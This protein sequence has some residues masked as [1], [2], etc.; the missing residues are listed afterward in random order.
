MVLDAYINITDGGGLTNGTYTLFTY[1]GTLTY[2][3]TLVQMA[4]N[5]NLAYVV[6][7]STNGQVNLVVSPACLT[8][9]TIL[10]PQSNTVSDVTNI[11]VQVCLP[12]NQEL[13]GI[14]FLLDGEPSMSI[15]EPGWSNDLVSAEWDTVCVTNG[16]HTLQ[17]FVSYSDGF[18]D[19]SEFASPIIWVQTQNDIILPGFPTVFGTS[20]P[21]TA[22]LP[23]SNATWTVN[24]LDPSNNTLRTYSDSTTTGRIDIVWDGNDSNGV[25][26][27]GDYVLVQ[28]STLPAGGGNP[29]VMRPAPK[30]TVGG[31]PNGFLLSYEGDLI[32]G[33][34]GTLP[35]SFNE[36]MWEITDIAGSDPYYTTGPTTYNEIGEGDAGVQTPAVWQS[37]L[38]WLSDPGTANLYYFGHGDAEA[39]GGSSGASAS[40]QAIG[41]ALGNGYTRLWWWPFKKLYHVKHTYRFVYLDGCDT[42]SGDLCVAF[43]IERIRTNDTYYAANGIQ[44][45]AFLGWTNIMQYALVTHADFNADLA[46]FDDGVFY[47]WSQGQTPLIG[48]VNQAR[49]PY[50]S[51]LPVPAIWGDQQLRWNPQ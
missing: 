32:Y 23:S 29:Q 4:P 34:G 38:G 18:G 2:D 43:G 31:Y 51:S 35:A 33:W 42:A 46:A 15:V 39:V 7:T 22:L 36:M 44:P 21:I 19:S 5:T 26:F 45:Q 25:S 16:W 13:G 27:S 14:Y 6:D 40:K 41:D 50:T 1:G 11:S 3:G 9:I 12:G 30:G 10:L 37:W 48:A 17:A 8:N 24:I 47:N 49:A 20:L 28:V